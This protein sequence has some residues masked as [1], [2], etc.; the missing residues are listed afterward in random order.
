VPDI[1]DVTKRPSVAVAV[2]AIC[3]AE[4]LERCLAALRDQDAAPPFQV[5]VR[6]DP[7]L[8]GIDAVSRRH[9]GVDIGC[10]ARE[11]TP[12]HL[13]A[14]ALRASNADVLLLTED[15][16]IPGRDWVRRMLNARR[17]DRAVIGGRVEIRPGASPVDWAFYFVDFFRYADP[18]REG[19]SPTLTVCNVAYDRVRL[20]SIRESWSE[21]FEEPAVHDA[22]RERYGMLWLTPDSEV[23]MH[24]NV[25]FVGAVR[26]R[27]A[28]GRIFGHT[29][30]ARL[31]PG[32]RALYGLLA[33]A[34]P[35]LLLG[36]MTAKAMRSPALARSYFRAFPPLVALVVA[37]SFG[38]WLGYVSGRPPKSLVLAAE[39]P[40]ADLPLT[41]DAGEQ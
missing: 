5:V 33:P 36:R 37:W 32:R 13:A 12:L 41:P 22:L 15:H 29:R 23:V 17:P 38:E 16:C 30:G 24:R 34:L 18:A 3:G 35:L 26:E 31:G 19:P 21:S 40:P 20:E 39:L 25:S 9:P 6:Y 4:H 2:V 10:D 14:A 28:F 1:G 11:R 7:G 8:P 27:Y